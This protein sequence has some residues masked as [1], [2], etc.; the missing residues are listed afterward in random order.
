MIEIPKLKNNEKIAFN[1]VYNPSSLINSDVEKTLTADCC[2][3][4]LSSDQ[5]EIFF[6]KASAI[7][8]VSSECATNDLAFSLRDS[9]IVE[10]TIFILEKRM[11]ISKS[12]SSSGILDLMIISSLCA[13]VSFII[14][15]G[16]NKDSSREQISSLDFPE[17]INAE[18]RQL[19]SITNSIF[20]YH[21]FSWYFFHMDFLIFLPISKAS[22]SVSLDLAVT[23][24]RIFN[25]NTLSRI[26]SLAISDQ[27]M[28]LDL[29]ISVFKSDGTDKVIV[30]IFYPP[31]FILFNI[32]NTLNIFKSFDFAFIGKL[33]R[34]KM[35]ETIQTQPCFLQSGGGE[36]LHEPRITTKSEC[37]LELER[38]FP[39]SYSKRYHND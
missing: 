37:G 2:F 36:S 27:F 24:L 38:L 15:S 4:A 22:F 12:N 28:N 39:N 9:N 7:K 16:E 1:L 31:I 10:G 6:D 26:A 5:R 20:S 30:G 33:K 8:G 34:K 32:F 3:N 35:L 13:R 19:V 11:S 17:K 21:P 29:S 14:S 23:E 18:I 25:W